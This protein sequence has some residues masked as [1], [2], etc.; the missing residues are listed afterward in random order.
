MTLDSYLERIS[1]SPGRGAIP[2]YS[3]M[4]GPY[5]VMSPVSPEGG[6][7]YVLF[8]DQTDLQVPRPWQKVM[9]PPWDGNPTLLAR[10]I[11]ILA[12]RL[13]PDS[14]A[15]IYIDASFR[16]DCSLQAFIDRYCSGDLSLFPHPE[17]NSVR[18]EIEACIRCGKETESIYN[19]L[20]QEFRGF[21]D[22]N[23]VNLFASGFLYR[24]L[25]NKHLR[26]VM[27]EW[28]RHVVSV[29]VRDQISLPYALSAGNFQ[30][31][32]IPLNIYHNRY[33]Y[34]KL[35]RGSPV[36]DRW[37]WAVLRWMNGRS[38]NNQGM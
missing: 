31:S 8:T 9:L 20:P 4:V 25:R 23:D 18:E 3:V 12:H 16:V 22:R 21:L 30:A 5:D 14:N 10:A 24:Q 28:F 35:H 19:R 38:E 11:K 33:V 15:C 27:E 1:M 36:L 37:K 26:E 17:R 29:S 2:V 34:P 7:E 13:F 6:F 32:A